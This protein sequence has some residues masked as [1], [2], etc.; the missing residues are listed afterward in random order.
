M[1]IK[2]LALLLAMLCLLTLT[3]CTAIACGEEPAPTPDAPNDPTPPAPQ[4][5]TYSVTLLNGSGQQMT[6]IIIKIMKGDEQVKMVAYKGETVSFELESDTYTITLDTAQLEGTYTY[7]EALCTLT[8]EHPSTTL[9]LFLQA[10]ESESVFVGYPISKDYTAYHVGVGT[11]AMPLT[12]N[13]YTF[14][15][16]RP[17][18]AAIYTITYE[19]ETELAV[20]YHG[21]TFFVQGIDLSADTED[22]A[23][24]ENGLSLNV[25]ASNLGGDFVFA[26]K[27]TSATKCTLHIERAG[28]PG[29]RLEDQPWT[30]FL[31]DTS[32]VQEHL[33][34]KPAGT[35]TAVD[36]TDVTLSAVFNPADGYYHLG[37]VDGPVL[38]IDLTSDTPYISSIQTICA[39]QRMGL[40]IYD[41]NGNIVEKR[42]YNELFHQY[43]MPTDTTA[44]EG[45][46]I[47]VPLTAKLAEAILKFGEKSGW[48]A[49]GSEKNIFT[50]NLA[51]ASYNQTFA[52]L[53]F[54][55]YYA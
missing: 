42:S 4:M 38:F 49:P 6:D 11:Y 47:R 8:A 36:V 17:T 26:L 51:G 32:K 33:A 48:W 9:P 54:C 45:G 37:S 39:N 53:L 12:P 20:S 18:A 3:L 29:T 19:C 50:A 16:F 27:S 44:P 40:Y 15:V 43:G 10:P 31:E 21:S 14:L 52:W 1:K 13:D 30:P 7:D 46:D 35:F 41:D 55:G 5:T 28:D 22:L 2:H 23:K 34:L 25:Y 24:Y